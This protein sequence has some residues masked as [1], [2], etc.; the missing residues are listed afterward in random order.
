MRARVWSDLMKIIIFVRQRWSVLWKRTMLAGWSTEI[1]HKPANQTHTAPLYKTSS[2][3]LSQNLSQFFSCLVRQWPSSRLISLTASYV[4]HCIS[5]AYK[6][7]WVVWH[8]AHR[9][10]RQKIV[11]PRLFRELMLNQESVLIWTLSSRTVIRVWLTNLLLNS[12]AAP[13]QTRN[14]DQTQIQKTSHEKTVWMGFVF[15]VILK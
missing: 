1:R 4:P 13:L 3:L 8:K 14:I 9:R 2:Q 10:K 15:L 6:H 11:P 5:V 7:D 12:E